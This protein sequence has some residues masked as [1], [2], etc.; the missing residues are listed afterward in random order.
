[1]VYGNLPDGWLLVSIGD[2]S[3]FNGRDAAISELPDDYLVTF[4]PMAAVDA[5]KGIIAQPEERPLKEVR[6]GFT[7]FSDGDVLFAK[8][9][10]SMENGKAAIAR[11]LK[12][13]RGFGS[14][15]FHVF[16]PKDK[17]ISDWIFHFIR[18]ESFRKDA[19]AHFAGTAGQLRVPASFLHEYPIPVPP[20]PEQERIVVKIEELFTQLEAGTTALER[21]QA[22]VKR[23]KASV[24]KAA[25]EGKLGIQNDEA[26]TQDDGQ[27]PAGWKWSTVAEL[28]ADEPYSITDGPFGS[29]LKTEHYTDSGPRVIRLQNI[30]DG[31]FR[32]EKSHISQAHFETLKRHK[33]YAGD[34]V[35]AGLGELLPRACIIP[36]YVGDAIVK[37]DCIRFKPNPII[38]DTKY[39]LYALNSDPVKKRVAKVVHGI[40]RPRMNQQE[41]KAIPIPLPPLEEQRQIVAE[42]ERR[43]SLA[44]GVESTLAA[45]L[46]R[47]GRLRQSILKSAF[48]GRLV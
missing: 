33:I 42:V 3:Q 16:R 10:P 43:L 13:G 4:L 28:A 34:L 39:L 46:S 12:N 19:K 17:V 37:A 22:G 27:L 48:E 38:A 20:L 41:I 5:E 45:S 31:E 9:T 25:V 44:A 24:L 11:K 6:K 8:I 1:M 47:A 26:R 36:E 18:Q 2:V 14:T 30:G 29:K 35:I 40:G 15:E 21:V 7:P 23:Y 32:D